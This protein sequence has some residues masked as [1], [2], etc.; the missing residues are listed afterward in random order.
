MFSSVEIVCGFMC[1]LI[2]YFKYFVW[3]KFVSLYVCGVVFILA[4]VQGHLLLYLL[5]NNT[6]ELGLGCVYACLQLDH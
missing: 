5:N 6:A 4:L 1:L 3:M 2:W